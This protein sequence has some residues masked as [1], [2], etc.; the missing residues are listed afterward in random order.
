[1]LVTGFN[2]IDI[3]N[4]E[5]NNRVSILDFFKE[6]KFENIIELIRLGN[7]NCSPT[8]A[9]ELLDNYLKNGGSI[10]DAILEIKEQL[11]G[12]GDNESEDT[13]KIDISEYKS[14]TDLYIYY[15]MQLLSVGL[16]YQEF[17]SMNTREMYKVFNSIMIKVENETNTNLQN[18]HTLA[19]MVG[20]AVWGKLQKEPPKIEH[21]KYKSSENDTNDI[22]TDDLIMIANLKSFVNI[23]NKNLEEKQNV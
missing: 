13:N 2:L 14:L 7:S 11:I 3:K 15:S 19:A 4:Y 23:H 18:Y 8:E 22:D 16:S 6:V 20:A 1:M 21:S 12:V 9:A 17:W 10:L 5:I